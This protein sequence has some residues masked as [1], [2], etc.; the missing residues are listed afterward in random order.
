MTPIKIVKAIFLPVIE[1]SVLLPLLMF[2]VL[3]SLG[4]W[5]FPLG[6]IVVILTL[7]PLFRYQSMLLESG[8][9]GKVPGAFDAEFFDW[10]G[11][12]WTLFPLPLAAVLV[13]GGVYAGEAWGDVGTWSAIALGAVVYPA[14]MALLAISH[15]PLEALNPLAMARLYRRALSTFWIAPLY[16]LAAIWVSIQAEVLPTSVAVFIQLFLFFSFAALTGALIQ[17]FDL[18]SDVHIPDPIEK[19]EQTIAGDIEMARTLALSHAYGFISRDNREGGFRHLMAET[20]K[21]P[22]PAGAWAWY[23]D[24]MLGWENKQHALFFGQ[25][26]VADMLDH[27]EDIPALK[28]IMRCRLVDEGFKPFPKDVPRAISAAERN[29]NIE[30]GA[31]L[32]RG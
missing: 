7:P 25:H 22:D 6:V 16:L 32:K 19:D 24:R 10:V 18:I 26:H 28:A 31:V 9:K 27:G 14:S 20:R 3:V 15:S 2:W 21:D 8:A 23:F 11:T 30:L 1:V 12:M 29:G 4:I 5:S 17:P 13:V